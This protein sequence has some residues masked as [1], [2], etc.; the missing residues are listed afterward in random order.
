MSET[1]LTA[2]I[3]DDEPLARKG[4]RSLLRVHPEIE[5]VAEVGRLADARKYLAKTVPDL[6]F[7]DIQL[8]GESGFDL[9]GD[10]PE[11]TDIIFVTAFDQYAVRA[12]EVNALDYLLK[13]VN[14]ARLCAALSRKKP[15]RPASPLQQEDRV[16]LQLGRKRWFESVENIIAICAAE[17]HSCVWTVEGGRVLGR[18]SLGEWEALL[19]QGR[20]LRIHRNAIVHLGHVGSSARLDGGGLRI[21]LRGTSDTL[22]V[23]RRRTPEFRRHLKKL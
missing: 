23:S 22:E 7:L 9:L 6:V 19:P 10:L 15:P 14:P 11:T 16:F 12:F 1:R 13:P 18:R 2:L 8:Y 3:V 17:D 5:I 4:L 21:G 20:F